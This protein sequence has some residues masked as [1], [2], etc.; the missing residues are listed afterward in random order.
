MTY[1]TPLLTG[2]IIFA[3]TIATTLSAPPPVHAADPP[4]TRLEFIW[5]RG[6]GQS[7]EAPSYSAYERAISAK[8]QL[9]TVS[10][11]Y[12][13]TEL[14]YPAVSVS[15]TEY[16]GL[17]NLMGAFVSSG[18]SFAYG[19]S[20]NSGIAKLDGYL[21]N[22]QSA[23]PTTSFALAGYSQ[24]AQVIADALPQLAPDRILY[25]ALLGE[26]RL[27][28]PE[29]GSIFPAACKG[30]NISEY[31][32]WAPNCYTHE[33]SLGP[34]LSY[35]P[36]NWSGKVGLWCNTR[37]VIC[38]SSNTFSDLSLSAA[39]HDEYHTN[40]QM[41]VVANQIFRR[42][43]ATI[44]AGELYSTGLSEPFNTAIPP[45][46]PAMDVVIMFDVSGSM[47]PY[48]NGFR[49]SAVQFSRDVILAGGR[50]A[51]VEYCDYDA[52]CDEYP[53]IRNDFS[54]NY[55]QVI[56]NIRH[57]TAEDLS[58]G[59]NPEGLLLGLQTAFDKLNWRPGATK[60]VV[61]LT[62]DTYHDPDRSHLTDY[63]TVLRR[64][65][66]IDPV[67]VFVITRTAMADD[68]K[69]LKLTSDTAGAIFPIDFDTPDAEEH[70][71]TILHSTAARPV[72][73]LPLEHYYA[74]PHETVT[75]DAS[76]SYGVTAPIVSYEWDFDGNGVY[77]LA[78]SDQ[79]IITHAWTEPTADQIVVVRVTDSTG[80]V[81]T[82]SAPVTITTDPPY[83]A[84]Y[85]PTP[86]PPP[87]APTTPDTTPTTPDTA[88]TTPDTTSTTNNPTSSD[89][90][91]PLAPE[92]SVISSDSPE[93]GTVHIPF[94][95]WLLTIP[96]F[97]AIMLVLWK[98]KQFSS[99]GVQATSAVTPS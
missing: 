74:Q 38:G 3:S 24:G 36:D 31:N 53:S 21:T 54:D 2:L 13:I 27:F 99:P 76:L 33:G 19:S 37:D 96:P 23:C 84:N 86:P 44:P 1:K 51:V 7:L 9:E 52:D 40:G 65:L 82:M 69:L 63:E 93:T 80:Q 15:P 22:R 92:S 89:E 12:R 71:S 47:I 39:G 48:I 57:I 16:A 8:L 17:F 61:V 4:C 5:L 95:P 88:P 73:L 83:A 90:T 58:G 43:A 66:E 11:S 70:I 18:R 68:P 30:E 42:A 49:N 35:V 14:D 10:A 46:Q 50:V 60:S 81:A 64:S 78:P 79:P 67:N 87:A 45:I 20:V 91:T 62:D 41:N 26:P 28:L 25:A 56:S 59:D 29:G 6:S 77:D 32:V 72:A 75:F 85:A 34:R 55:P 94:W 97:L 98:R